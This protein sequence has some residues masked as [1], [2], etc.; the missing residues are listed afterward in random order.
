MKVIGMGWCYADGDTVKEGRYI[1]A[2][3]KWKVVCGER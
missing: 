2:N 1:E 3:S